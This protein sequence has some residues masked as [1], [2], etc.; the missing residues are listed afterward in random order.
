[1]SRDFNLP[2]CVTFIYIARTWE[3]RDAVPGLYIS[4]EFAQQYRTAESYTM[5]FYIIGVVVALSVVRCVEHTRNVGV[6][7]LRVLAVTA[8]L[9][10]AARVGEEKRAYQASTGR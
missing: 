6:A 1:M 9:N 8:C 3:M 4:N 7:S 10:F 2:E 5:Y